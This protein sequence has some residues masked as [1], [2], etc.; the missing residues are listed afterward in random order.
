M[1]Y[2]SLRRSY[3]IFVCM[4]DLFERGRTK[5][6]FRSICEEDRDLPL[7]DGSCIMFLNT[8]GSI[9][10]D[11]SGLYEYNDYGGMNT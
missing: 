5:Y 2:G 9:G 3:V 7:G 4:F 11:R 6:T 8:K 10:N 1:E